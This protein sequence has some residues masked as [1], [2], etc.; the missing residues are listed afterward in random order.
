MQDRVVI[1]TPIYRSSLSA[2]ESLSLDTL[3]KHL[4]SYPRCLIAPESLPL[5]NFPDFRVQRFAS[6]FFRDV[7]SYNHLVLTR[8][9]YERF[10]DFDFMLI[11]Q[12]DALVFRDE[13][14]QWCDAQYDFIGAPVFDPTD[15]TTAIGLNGGFSL[16]SPRACLRVLQGG[17]SSRVRETADGMPF[18]ERNRATRLLKRLLLTLHLRGLANVIP[19]LVLRS[20][21]HEDMFWS[22]F[23]PLFDPEFRVA[24]V[25]DAKKF[26][27]EAH[28]SR[29][30]EE[31]SRQLPFGCH[32]WKRWDPVFWEWIL[33]ENGCAQSDDPTA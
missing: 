12:L 9:F 23:A 13:L 28:A 21:Y 1:V 6:R 17:A 25:S 27:F 8:G 19:L 24:P 7:R 10:R 4:G 29:L 3:R 22:R 32:A 20:G 30:Y 5:S 11:Y 14:L 31:N 26:A 16:R 15:V 18:M 33:K 2:E